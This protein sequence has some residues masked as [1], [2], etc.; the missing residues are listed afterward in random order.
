[1]RILL[2][3]LMLLVSNVSSAQSDEEI[4]R[5]NIKEFS[6]NLMNGHRDLVVASYTTDAKIMPDRTRILEGRDLAEYWNPS[7]PGSWKTIYH[8][9]TPEEIKVIGDTAYDYGYYEGTSSNGEKES[10]WKG[11]YV[12]VWKKLKSEWKI[13]LDIWNRVED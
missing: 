8:K 4:I 13:Y 9:V 2:P 7:N 11:K 10:N 5:Q 6:E 1:M 12:I 3:A